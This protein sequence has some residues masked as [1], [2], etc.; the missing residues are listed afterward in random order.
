MCVSVHSIHMSTYKTHIETSARQNLY[1]NKHT[2][3]Q[4]RS[5]FNLPKQATIIE[6]LR[7]VNEFVHVTCLQ[8]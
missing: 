1:A 4:I 6:A 5:G 3:E 7:Y 8:A 2:Y